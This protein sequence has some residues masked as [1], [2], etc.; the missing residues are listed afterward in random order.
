M[1]ERAAVRVR[2]KATGREYSTYSP[3]DPAKV[4]RVD[5]PA[6]DAGSRLLP[7]K[8]R[9]PAGDKP[10]EKKATK[11]AAATSPEGAEPATDVHEEDTK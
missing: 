7:P 6:T 3:V 10:A 2:S 5:K 4:Q 9:T 8:N 11:K 1:T